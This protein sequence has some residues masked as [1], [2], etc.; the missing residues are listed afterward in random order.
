MHWSLV[1]A[2]PPDADALVVPVH[3]GRLADAPVPGFLAACGFTGTPGEVAAL[4]GEGGGPARVLLGCGPAHALDDEAVR[5]AAAGLARAVRGFRRIAVRLPGDP[6]AEGAARCPAGTTGTTGTAG[7]AALRPFAE[8][9]LLGGYRF[10]RHKSAPGGGGPDRVDVLVPDPADRAARTAL[11][12]G[13]RLA[14]AVLLARD[15]VNEPGQ[16]VTPEV[17]ADRAREVAGAAG[18]ACEV[19]DERRIAA[20]RLGG[21]LAVARGSLRPPRLVRLVFEPERPSARWRWSARA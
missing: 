21:L 2:C 4:P 20:E 11:R 7:V 18:L 16:E 8:G 6:G 12:E 19:W 10:T 9:F 5:R 15:L 3:A 1:P 13:R 17:F 14:G